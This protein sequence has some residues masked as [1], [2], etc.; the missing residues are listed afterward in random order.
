MDS[1]NR[2]PRGLS[3]PPFPRSDGRPM[4]RVRP[5]N[6]LRAALAGLAVVL[7][8]F[9]AAGA[10]ILMSAQVARAAAVAITGPSPTAGINQNP[11][12][13][14]GTGTAGDTVTL[15]GSLLTASPCASGVTVDSGG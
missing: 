5:L 11:V 15:T 6:R 2:P 10:I 13:F 1:R 12:L 9:S 7:L 4:T 8:T 3:P 14:N